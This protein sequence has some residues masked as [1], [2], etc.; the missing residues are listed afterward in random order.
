M[1]FRPYRQGRCPHCGSWSSTAVLLAC[2]LVCVADQPH[3][4]PT[5][6]L[7]FPHRY[8]DAEGQKT[9]PLDRRT[10]DVVT[11][12]LFV[13]LARQVLLVGPASV[14][15]ISLDEPVGAL[16]IQQPIPAD[17]CAGEDGDYATK[18]RKEH[19]IRDQRLPA[20][21]T[22]AIIVQIQ[23]MRGCLAGKGVSWAPRAGRPRRGKARCAARA[24]Q[25][26]TVSVYHQFLT[27][28]PVL[29]NS[30]LCG[31]STVF[32]YE[33]GFLGMLRNRI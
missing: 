1:D 6:P 5:T 31:K 4:Q 10:Q 29:S 13:E 27:L 22:A 30:G 21:K 11:Q 8:P 18:A 32:T 26:R 17:A 20:T 25:S 16:P 7:P 24:C 15:S 9:S 33:I 14:E 19:H 12:P 28:A 3:G 2:S 23:H